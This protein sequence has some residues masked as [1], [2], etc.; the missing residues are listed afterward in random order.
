MGIVS[1][2]LWVCFLVPVWLFNH[3]LLSQKATGPHR[4]LDTPSW[5]LLFL[6]DETQREGREGK[7]R[8]GTLST[9]PELCRPLRGRERR[10]ERRRHEASLPAL[11][12][13]DQ[14]FLLHLCCR[15][16]CPWVV[17]SVSNSSLLSNSGAR[18]LSPGKKQC[19]ETKSQAVFSRANAQCAA[20]QPGLKTRWGFGYPFNSDVHQSD[21]LKFSRRLQHHG[22]NTSKTL[23]RMLK[24]Q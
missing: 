3:F 12:P 19:F 17:S 14:I 23:V 4:T 2:A 18:Y 24:R 21:R 13:T 5:I 9:A 16:T 10:K 6:A 15:Q 7:G 20:L 22:A 8:E 11:W 1:N